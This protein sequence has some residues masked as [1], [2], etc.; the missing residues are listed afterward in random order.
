MAF[1]GKEKDKLV[2]ILKADK[3]IKILWGDNIILFAWL[4]DN[5]HS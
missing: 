5:N 2:K 1:E 4:W 3:W